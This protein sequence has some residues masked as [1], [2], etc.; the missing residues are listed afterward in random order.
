MVGKNKSL[1]FHDYFCSQ[2]PKKDYEF[3]VIAPELNKDFVDL[4]YFIIK[5]K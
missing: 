2:N 3:V 1:I 4:L 5:G